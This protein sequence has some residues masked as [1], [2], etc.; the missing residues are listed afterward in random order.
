MQ[1]RLGHLPSNLNKVKLLYLC[2][3]ELILPSLFD[4]LPVSLKPMRVS[5]AFSTCE[6]YTVASA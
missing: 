4:V 6:Q 1:V 5:I 2:L 3:T